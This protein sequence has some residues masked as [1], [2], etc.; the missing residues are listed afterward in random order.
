MNAED[1]VLKE[2]E[3]L[4]IYSYNGEEDRG[5]YS[6]RDFTWLAAKRALDTQ[7]DESESKHSDDVKVTAYKWGERL[8]LCL[9]RGTATPHC[10]W[11][12]VF[13]NEDSFKSFSW[14]ETCH[15]ILE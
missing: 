10:C 4:F 15:R 2:L 1:T 3:H 11:D 9:M 7:P 8:Q 13:H 6:W 12:A 14:L 5:T